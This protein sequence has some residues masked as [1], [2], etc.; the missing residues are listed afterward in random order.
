[1]S[2]AGEATDRER[3]L[4]ATLNLEVCVDENRVAECA[5]ALQ[6]RLSPDQWRV[7]ALLSAEVVAR[8]ESVAAGQR[9]LVVPAAER[10][11]EVARALRLRVAGVD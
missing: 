3:A 11:A 1:M 4:A 7:L 2:L 6:E 10:Q 5:K 8:W 9:I